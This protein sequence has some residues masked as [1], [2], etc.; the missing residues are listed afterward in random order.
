MINP[1]LVRFAVASLIGL[2]NLSGISYLTSRDARKYQLM[3][4]LVVGGRSVGPP[5]RGSYPRDWVTLRD[6]MNNVALAYISCGLSRNYMGRLGLDRQL[7]RLEIRPLS[8]ATTSLFAFQYLSNGLRHSLTGEAYI[9][10]LLYRKYP[11]G[12]SKKIDEP[13]S[14]IK[15]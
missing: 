4:C 15:W 3:K 11:V 2:L 6:H 10:G 5:A 1:E 12:R 9:R 14:G 13:S 7:C 8:S